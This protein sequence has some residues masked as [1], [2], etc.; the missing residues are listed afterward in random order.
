MV[1]GRKFLLIR[2]LE[3]NAEFVGVEEVAL[4]QIFACSVD[5]RAACE[6]RAHAVELFVLDLARAHDTGSRLLDRVG[7]TV[8]DAV[9]AVNLVDGRAAVTC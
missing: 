9:G 2:V 5:G 8:L 7:A 1:M 3:A 4:F 6:A